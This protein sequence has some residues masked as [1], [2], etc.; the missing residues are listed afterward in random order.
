MRDAIAGYAPVMAS[1]DATLPAVRAWRAL[2]RTLLGRPLDQ[3]VQVDPGAP[4]VPWGRIGS[5]EAVSRGG[6]LLL[7]SPDAGHPTLRV[8]AGA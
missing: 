7:L 8:R 1:S 6:I 4:A 2:R 5:Y 3:E